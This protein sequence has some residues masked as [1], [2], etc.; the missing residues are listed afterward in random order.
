MK[1][2]RIYMDNA[3]TFEKITKLAG[4][5]K[6][7]KIL[8]FLDSKEPEVVVAALK[9]LS[10]IKDEDSVNAIDHRIDSENVEIRKEAA[11]ALGE[12][13]TEYAK[14]HLQHKMASEQDETVKAAIK[15]ALKKI[16]DSRK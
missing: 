5:K 8:K 1:R 4:K 7:A 14:T 6:S 3:R 2:G 10:E 15:E 11:L 12:I 13:G 16:A 9:A